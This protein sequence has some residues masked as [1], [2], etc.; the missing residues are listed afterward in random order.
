MRRGERSAIAAAKDFP[1]SQSAYGLLFFLGL[2]LALCVAAFQPAPGYMDAD[3]YYATG[4]QLALGK[5]FAEPFLWNYL[6]DP[7][8]LPHPSH[9]YWM[10]FAGILAAAGIWLSQALAGGT[11][12][13]AALPSGTVDFIAARAGF[14][15]LAACLPPVTA[16]LATS[17]G[18]NRQQSW[19]AGLLAL[20]PGFYLPFLT[21]TD[22]FGIYML[23]G[24]LF[25]Q[26]CRHVL[27]QSA[28]GAHQAV[29]LLSSSA[30]LGAL[31]GL[32]HLARADGVIWILVGLAAV[33]IATGRLSELK[34]SVAQNV[35]Y[36]LCSVAALLLGYLLVVSPWIARNLQM[37]GSFAAPGAARALWITRYDE[38]FTYPAAQL[39][40][41]R[42]WSSGLQ[43]LIGARLWALGQNLQTAVAVQ[44][45]V[46]LAPLILAGLWRMRR[47]TRV[48]L[49]GLAWVLTFLAMTLVFPFQGGRGGWFHSGAA[50][51]PVF[52][53]LAP[54]GLQAVLEWGEVRRGWVSRQAGAAVSGGLVGLAVLVTF[55]TASPR[56]N[57][58]G[59][60]G[61]SWGKAEASYVRMEKSLREAGAPAE[62]SVLVNN[63]PGY[64]GATGRPALVIPDGDETAILAVARRYHGAYLLLE[65]NHPGAL[66][67]LY[68]SPGDRPGLEY[69]LTVD[70]A[71]IFYIGSD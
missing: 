57:G 29:R 61:S 62:A 8:G 37:G 38:L 9:L 70:S 40:L 25:L 58:A 1:M 52:W 47:D 65:A 28:A 12:S 56:L 43:E 10:P 26:A 11:I 14:L 30:L 32:M 2:S 64:F 24:V 3:Y 68:R 51:Q 45:E 34:G 42:W 60:A 35:F 63:P 6:D 71:H 27:S 18:G 66:E 19:M 41:D 7:A 53:A 5:G 69:L 44:G 55:M 49:G 23:L 21:T 31:A 36:R 67:D 22:T 4:R 17:F 15:V 39:T 13:S 46:F 48:Q 59:E 20:F 16:A 33:W 50:L 54:V